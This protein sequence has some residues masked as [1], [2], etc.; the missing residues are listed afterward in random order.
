MNNSRRKFIK[1]TLLGGGS[2][3]TLGG[4]PLSTFAKEEFVK[5][6]ILHTNDV[7]S[8][9][10]PFPNNDPLYPGMGGASKRASIINSV[11]ANE[12]N[13]L[14]LDAGDIFQ[15]TPYFNFYKGELDLKL[16]SAMQYDAAT[17]GNHD[18]DNGIEGLS[19]MMP[20]ANFPF[21][22]S[23]YIFNDTPL[24]GKVLPYKILEKEGIK[25]G[26]MGIG[27]Q[28]EGLVD[29][30]LYGN[31]IYIN[32]IEK[33]NQ[34]A[35]FLKHEKQCNMVV[36]L[37]HL[38]YKYSSSVVSDVVLA[39]ESKDIDIIIGGHSHTFLEQAVIE[40]NKKNKPVYICQ[41]GFAGLLLGK[42]E[43]YFKKNTSEMAVNADTIKIF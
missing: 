5:L 28:L 23:N 35:Q 37:S 2:F 7:H 33:A 34:V 15:G 43:C 14:L 10:E 32:P 13:V 31:T 19:N 1:Q 27:V 29:K 40:K 41:A 24:S 8:R 4:I 16:M 9:I 25:I 20:Y 18:F 21:I 6:T 26:V 3:I 12:K 38:G 39:N 30:K 22:S 36:V 42:I 17:I 11:R